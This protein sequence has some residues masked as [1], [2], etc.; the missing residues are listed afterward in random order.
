MN[1]YRFRRSFTEDPTLSDR[2]FN[3]VEVVFPEIGVRDAAERSRQLGA[4]WESAS[5]PFIRFHEDL[6]ITHVG[7]LEIPMQLMGQDLI[8]GGIHGVCT[9]P[10]F[11]RR[12]YYREVMEEV[13]D[14]CSD[15]YKTLVLTTTQPEIYNPFGFRVV[16]EHIFTAKCDSPGGTNGFRVLD[17]TDSN[18]V[19]LLNR[20]LETRE[21]VSRILGV[22]KEKAVFYFNEGN[23][24]LYYAEDLDLVAVMEIED[25][26]LKLFDL[27]GTQICTLEAILERISQPI[28][29]VEIYF[30]PE[31]L[32]AKVQAFPHILGGELFLMVRGTFPPEGEKFMLPRSARC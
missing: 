19:K 28:N 12:G 24:P 3:L 6:A 10:E 23:N 11:R 29:E 8:V 27:V 13:L 9:H 5:T 15:R 21:P 18:D 30:S 32:D 7:V 2:L 14:Y 16:G 26:K 31:R 22:V 20:L 25:S 4:S 17:T 1:Q